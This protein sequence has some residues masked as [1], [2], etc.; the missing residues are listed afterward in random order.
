MQNRRFFMQLYFPVGKVIFCFAKLYSPTASYIFP[1]GKVAVGLY[2]ILV[3]VVDN[4]FFLSFGVHI[5]FVCAAHTYLN[6]GDQ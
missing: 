4:L 6:V 2:K 3:G 1:Y 5:R